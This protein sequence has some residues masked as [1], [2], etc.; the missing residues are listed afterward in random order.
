MMMLSG[1]PGGV[2]LT[3]I[4]GSFLFATG[5]SLFMQGV[6]ELLMPKPDKNKDKNAVFSGPVNNVKQGQPVPLLYGELIVGG[7]PISATF[8]KTKITSTGIA[9][10]SA[11]STYES[12]VAYDGTNGAIFTNEGNYNNLYNPMEAYAAYRLPPQ[13]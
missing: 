13:V 10:N 3:Q 1:N 2:T 8:T 11:R 6:N 5:L 4:G 7:A 9:Y 12:T